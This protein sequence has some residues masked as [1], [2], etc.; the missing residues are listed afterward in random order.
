[1]L[2][3]TRYW[4]GICWRVPFN[5]F[6]RPPKRLKLKSLNSCLLAHGYAL[7]I[8]DVRGTGASFGHCPY[9]WHADTIQDSYEIVDWIVTQPWSNGRVGAFGVS[10]LGTT[11]EL[12]PACGHPAVRAILPKFNH[13]DAYTD[14]AFP[15]GLF[16]EHF[17]KDW[18]ALD[19]VL[20]RNIPPEEFGIMR[21]MLS[22]VKPVA[23]AEKALAQA[24]QEHSTNS[25]MYELARRA[26]FRDQVLPDIQASIEDMVVHRYLDRIQASGAAICGWGSWF[27][28]GTADAVLRRFLTL[29]NPGM[30]VIGAWEHGGQRNASPYRSPK[31]PTDPSPSAQWAETVRFF[32]AY[33][34]EDQPGLPDKLLHYY[35]IGE[36]TWKSSPTWPPQGA[37]MQRWHLSE[38]GKLSLQAP[39]QPEGEDAYQVNLQAST[40]PYNRWWEMSAMKR[41]T[42]VYPKRAEAAQHLLAYLTPPFERP[43]EISGYPVIKLFLRSTE[44]DGAIFVYIEDVDE[45]G[46][47]YYLTEGELRAIHRKVSDASSPYRLQVPYHTFKQDDASP[48]VPGEVAELHFGL[49]PISALIRK[50]HRLRLAIACS[51]RETFPPLPGLGEPLVHVQRNQVYASYL[52][53][54][55]IER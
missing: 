48:L 2:Q 26:T 17:I 25:N 22:G 44:T 51:D 31:A 54:P 45:D 27:D 8:V 12:L 33:M 43:I 24:V 50:S 46:Q 30:A 32:D 14:I 15:G 1:L 6:F 55:I 52:D 10:Y 38:G 35:T 3:Q 19:H 34:K 5:W 40:G 49:N 16:N 13:P 28:A 47:V 20:D 21:P 41:L 53:L 9:P 23:G 37:R 29:E 4:R 39:H 42:V 36:E 18:G 7:L 11:A